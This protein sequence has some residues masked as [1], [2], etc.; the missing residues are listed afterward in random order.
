MTNLIT[1]YKNKSA[2]HWK[3]IWIIK[4]IHIRCLKQ[5]YQASQEQMHL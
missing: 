2:G 4:R 5:S 3:K 1:F